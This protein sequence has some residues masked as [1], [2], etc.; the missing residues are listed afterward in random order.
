MQKILSRFG[1]DPYTNW[2]FLYS[3]MLFPED[4][5]TREAIFLYFYFKHIFSI[6][7]TPSYDISKDTHKEAVRGLIHL[8]NKG[9]INKLL[10][11]REKAVIATGM[12]TRIIY[13]AFKF[14]KPISL[15]RAI[16]IFLRYH[17]EK[18]QQT[19]SKPFNLSRS[20]IIEYYRNRNDA[21][22]FCA[23]YT[24]L[25]PP[26][27][28]KSA[29]LMRSRLWP[30]IGLSNIYL[31]FGTRFAIGDPDG[32]TNRYLID[33]ETCFFIP[34]PTEKDMLLHTFP[35]HYSENILTYLD[36]YR[37]DRRGEK[38]D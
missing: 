1:D 38:Y 30:F 17:A 22:H 24:L 13:T 33:A 2:L 29:W 18:L 8:I 5:K 23:A 3:H 21:L 15:S 34:N 10:K 7:T 32:R 4:E 9:D 19:G 25:K 16:F 20:K 37:E 26:L 36:H 6:D 27:R 11:K 12:L 31:E 35:L 14:N 28:I